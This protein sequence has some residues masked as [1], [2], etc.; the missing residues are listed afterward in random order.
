MNIAF[1]PALPAKP[2]PAT[3]SGVTVFCM[4]RSRPVA[5]NTTSMAGRPHIEMRRYATAPDATP[6]AAPNAA[7]MAGTDSDPAAA[8]TAPSANASHMPSIPADTAPAASPPPSLR[9]TAGVVE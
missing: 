5:A 1:N 3:H 8:S 6:G 7:T 2:S 4:P 9:A